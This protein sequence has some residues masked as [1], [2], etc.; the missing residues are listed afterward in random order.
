MV[1]SVALL[2]AA[3]LITAYLPVVGERNG[4]AP[5]VVGALLAARGLSAAASRMLLGHLSRR[6]SR[7]TLVLAST[8]GGA[9]TTALLAITAWVPL[10]AVALVLGGFLLGL[11]QP[12]T[13]TQVALA[14]SRRGRSEALALRLVGNRVAQAVIPLAAG[15][16]AVGLG[17]G[18][19]FWLQSALLVAATVWEAS[20]RDGGGGQV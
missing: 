11:G 2:T 20:S 16:V 6:W 7:R 17:V 10:L 15:S 4:I 12:L 3:D 8:I 9:V 13:M 1:V 18:A 19:A 5:V 14:V